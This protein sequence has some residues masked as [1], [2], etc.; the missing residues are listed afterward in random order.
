MGEF[1]QMPLIVDSQGLLTTVLG[2]S[3]C[4]REDWNRIATMVNC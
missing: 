2:R 3:R 4:K 1:I